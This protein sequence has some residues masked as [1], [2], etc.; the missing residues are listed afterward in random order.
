MA[1]QDQLELTQMNSFA[2]LYQII[3]PSQTWYYTSFHHDVDFGGQPYTARPITRGEFSFSEGLRSVRVRVS[4]PLDAPI[5]NYIAAFPPDQTEIKIIRVFSGGV[6]Y[7]QVFQGHIIAVTIENKIAH[8]ECESATR[9]MRNK[10]PPYI[11]QAWC[12]HILYDENCGLNKLDWS[13]SAEVTAVDGKII[14][15]SDLAPYVE[16]DY[17]TLGY[18]EFENDV[19]FVEDYDGAGVLTVHFP[20]RDLAVTDTILVYPGCKKDYTD[21]GVAKFNNLARRL[22]FDNI[23]SKNPVIWGVK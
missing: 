15:S 7:V 9:L 6:D 22:A 20:F 4:A 11:F 10:V 13:V 16:V 12:N 14:S 23:P 3:T 17:F 19:R 5:L 21:C 1:Y 8:A 18:V 2:E